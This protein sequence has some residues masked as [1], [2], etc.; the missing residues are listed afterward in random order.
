MSTAPIRDGNGNLVTVELPPSPGRAA[1][2]ASRPV[3]LA[4]EDFAALGALAETAPGSDTAS[5]GI[6]GRLQR[7]AQR[8]TSLIALLPSS[9]GAKT[10]AN[11]LSVVP[12]SDAVHV[13]RAQGR[14]HE[15]IPASQT[16]Q[17]LGASG[18]AGDVLDG[19][20]IVPATT[21]PGQVSIEYGSTNIVVFQGGAD[22]VSNLVP[23][24]AELGGIASVG[25]GWEISTGANVS[26]IAVGDFT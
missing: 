26:A 19:L 7:I 23:F 2:A 16:D 22:S 18:A 25:G 15:T 1:A 11:S 17:M 12:A 24:W 6:N 10:G 3:V 14:D 21:S 5:A 20:L 9:L 4:S 13:V 8:L